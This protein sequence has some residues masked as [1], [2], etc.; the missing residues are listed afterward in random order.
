MSHALPPPGMH[1][2]E[3]ARQL[4]GV[5]KRALLKHMR[6]IGWLQVGGAEHNLPHPSYARKGWLT[7]QQR[8]HN[9]KGNKEIVR[10]YRVMIITQQGFQEL[11]HTMQNKT[12]T[13]AAAATPVPAAPTPPPRQGHSASVTP[14]NRPQADAKRRQAIQD[15]AAIGIIINQ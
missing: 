10:Q 1:D 9:L 4:L 11:K 14:F 6:E 15:L 7:T 8:S 13:P 3:S 12:T 2:A 5:S